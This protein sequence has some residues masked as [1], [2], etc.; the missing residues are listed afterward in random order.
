MCAHIVHELHRGRCV[1][2]RHITDALRHVLEQHL[3]GG[4]LARQSAR[5]AEARH[6]HQHIAEIF[7]DKLRTDAQL[8][9]GNLKV[10]AAGERLPRTVQLLDG[11]VPEVGLEQLS[12]VVA[13]LHVEIAVELAGLV[14]FGGQRQCVDA[15][16]AWVP[17]I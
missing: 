8:A 5:F 10:P 11:E 4:Y 13:E 17:M 12:L 2:R 16:R 3:V 7:F 6:P 15:L 14:L 1:A 9:G